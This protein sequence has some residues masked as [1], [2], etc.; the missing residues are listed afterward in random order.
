MSY[1]SMRLNEVSLPLTWG[2]MSLSSWSGVRSVGA[3]SLVL[4]LGLLPGASGCASSDESTTEGDDLTQANNEYTSTMRDLDALLGECEAEGKCEKV[5]GQANDQD[6][7]EAQSQGLSPLAGPVTFRSRFTSLASISLCSAL[8]PIAGL[9][10]PY[11]FIGGSAK[12]A[13][14]AT[15]ADAGVDQVF[16]LYNQQAAIFHYH[17][18]GYQ[19][20]IGAE[21]SAYAGYGFGKKAN[22]LDAWSGDF[23]TAEATVETPFLK[24]AAG[25]FIFRAPDN[26]IW[27]GAAEASF[28]FNALGPYGT[29]EVSVSEGFWTPWDKATRAYGKSLFFASNHEK[30]A[31]VSSSGKQHMYL[32][33][34]NTRAFAFAMIQNLH[35]LGFLPAAQAAGLATLKSRGISIER[36]CGK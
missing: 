2:T 16:D 34:D 26:S 31:K 10:R 29:V 30:W 5:S 24:I 33:F 36:M 35:T 11:F 32:Q 23:Q 21:V 27:G 20:L 4:V 7:L 22:V 12:A 28:G 1:A 8:K 13:L 9:Q 14:I 18:H 6:E 17:N 3:L 15:V 25:G 19:N